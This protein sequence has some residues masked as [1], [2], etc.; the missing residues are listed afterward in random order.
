MI[1]FNFNFIFCAKR[2]CPAGI[3]ALGSDLSKCFH[4]LQAIKLHSYVITCSFGQIPLWICDWVP[5]S[6]GFRFIMD[7]LLK[8]AG[9]SGSACAVNLLA[10]AAWR[11]SDLWTKQS[12]YKQWVNL[13]IN[14]LAVNKINSDFRARNKSPLVVQDKYILLLGKWP[15]TL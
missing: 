12:T 5:F 2:F 8:G 14:L 10:K 11:A 7:G 15:L 4:Y 6:A 13:H 3:L 9:N 1:A